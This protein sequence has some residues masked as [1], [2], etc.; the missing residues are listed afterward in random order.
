M[1]FFSVVTYQPLNMH[2]I[3][4]SSLQL[5]TSHCTHLLLYALLLCSYILAIA[6][7]SCYMHFFSVVTYQPLH[8]PLAIYTSSL[9]LH[10][11]HCTHLLYTL[12][13]CSYILA[14]AHTSCYMHFFSVVTYQPLHT[15]LICTSSLQL[16]TSHCTHLL[17]YALL[18]CS[19]I[20]AIAHTSCYMH[21]FS[22]VT[23]QPLHTPLAICT[24]SLQLHTSHCTH[25]LLYTLL[26]CS[27]I[28]AIA[29]TSYIHFFSVVIAH[30]SCYMHFFSVVTYQPLHT[31]LICTSSLQLHTSHCTHL[32]LY[33]LLL[34]S[35]TLAIAHTSC[36]MHF[37][38]VVTYQPLHT[39]LAMYT[40]SLQLHTSHCT[41][42]LLY[43][44]LLCSYILAI[45]HTSCYV[46]FFSVVTYQPLHTPLAICTSSLQLHT[47]HCTHLLLYALLLCSYI[48]ASAHTS[49]YM[50]FFSVVTYQPLHTSLAICTSSPQLR[51]SHCTHLLLYTLLLC[52]YI[53]AIAHTSCYMHFFSVVTYQ[54]LHTPLAICTSSLQ[55]HTSHC[56]HLLLYALLLCSDILA[57]AHTSCYVHFFSVVT[58]QL[59]HTPLAMYTS[60]L[61][62]H[63]SHCTH[64]LLYALLLCSYILAIAHTSCYIHFFSVVTYQPLHTPLAMYTSSLQ[65]HTSH[66]THLLLYALLLCSYIL[67]IAHTSCYVHFFSVVTYQPLH[68]PLAICTASLQLHTSHCT[69]LLLY[70]LLLCSY[71]LASAHTS[72]YMHFF[73][74]VTY[75]PLH[76][77][78]AICTSSL[79]LRTSHCT[80]LLLYT[81]LLCSYILAI[82][83]TSCYV[84]FFSVVTYQ[85][86]H[87]PLA[88]CTSSLQLHTSH[89]THLLLC[90]LLLCSYILAIAHTSCYMHFFSVVTYQPLHTPLAICTSSLQ[91]H[92]SHCTHLL[93]TLLLCSYIL[94]IAHTS[95]YMH[96]FS[97]VTYQPLNMHLICTSSLQLHTSHCTHLLLYALLL[98]SYIL[99]IAH[100]YCYMH[101]FSVVTYQP[102]HTPLAIYTSS[103]QL[104]TSHCTHLLY[105]L[106][107]CS[108]ILAMHFFSLHT[109]AHTSCYM[110][111]FS[112][113][114]YQPLHTHLICTSSLQLHTSHCTH[115]LLYALLLCSYIL[116]IAHTSC[117]MH[118]FSVVTYQPLHTPLAI[119]T[120]SLQLHTS[121]CT[122]LL[123]Y[124]LLLCSYILAIAHTSY[125]HFFSVVI[126]HTSCYMHFFSVVT[127]QPLHTHL[128]CTSSLQL[129][130]SHCTHLLLYA[131]LLCS[132]TLA[133]AHTSC[134]MHFFSVVTY[135]PLHTPLA[136]YTSSLQLHTSHCTHLLL[137]ALL[138]CSYILAIAHT[139]CYVHFFSVVTYQPLHTPLAICTSSLQLHTSH[140]THLLLYALLLCS[141][142]L[143]SAHTS[144]YMHFFS[145]V[146]YQPLHTSLAICTSSPQLRTSHCTHLLLYTL[147][148]C[149]YI[150]AIAHTSC[151]MHFFSVVTYQ[152]LHTPLAICTSSLQ[153]HTSHCT[154]LLLYALLL[155]S[156]ILAIA[157]TSC[158]MHFFSVVTYQPLHTPLAMYTSSLQLHTSHCTHLLLCT[159]LLCSYI[160]AIAHTSCYMHFFSVVTYQPLHTPLAIYTS[161]L[162][163]HT[164]H[165]THLLLCT[166]LLCSYILAIAHT[167]CY[168]H[169]FSVVTYQPLHTP[170]AMYTS[171]L[172]LHTSHCTHVLL[173]ALLLCSYILAIAH[174]SCYMHFFSVVTYQPVHTPLAICT[175]SL[176]LH[177]SHCTHLLL[178]ALL[179]CSYVLAIAHTSCYIH[180]FSVVTYQPL[181][182]PLAICTSSLQLHTSHC[183]HL[184]LYTLLLCS[185]I[186]AIAH[187]SCYVHFFSVVTY[188]PLHTPLAIC[189]S[190]LQLHTSHCTHLLLCTL[191][192]CSYI[193]AIA[194]TSCYMHFFSVVT[195][196]PLH[197]PLAICTSSLQLHTSQCT[198]LLLYALLLCSYVLAIEHTSC[199]IHFFSVVT[200]QPLHTPL[201]ICTSSLQL[202]QLHTS[203]CTHLLLYALLLCSYILTIAHTSCYMHFFS[204]VTYQPLHTPL[205]KCTSSL[206]LH[207]SHCTHLLLCTLLLC[208]YIL[209]IAHTSCY[210]PFF[211]VVTY[212]PLHTPLAIYTSSLQ[213]H[214]SHCTHLLLY[215]LLLCS[216]ILAIAHTSCY[217]H[218]FSVVTYQ[219]LHTPL[220]ICTSSL[221]LHTS[222]CTHLLLYTLLLCSYI[223]AIAHTSYIYFF[224]VVT[225]QPLHTPLAI[226]TSSLQL[227][228]SHC[229]RILYALLLC[230]YILAIAHISCYIHFFSVVTYQ[231]LHTP[232]AICTFFSVVT[233][234]PLHTPLAICTSSLQLHTSH[235]TH[236][237]LCTLLLCSY[238]LAIAHTSCYIH[239]FSVVTYQPLHTPL[240]ICTSSLQLHTSHCTH[241]LLYAL[242]LCSYILAIA[243]TSC[244]MHFFSVV[245]HQPLHTPLAIC[246]SSLQLH[247]SHCTH[248]F[249]YTL[250]LYSYIL[251]ISH[252]S[253]YMHFFSVVTHQPLHTP[254]AI[255]TS[256][257][258]LH[259]SHCT[260]LLLCTLLL[261]SYILAIAHTSCYMHFFS[262]VTY[263]PLHTPL[264]MY[265]S[266]LQLHTSHCTHLLLYALLL[267][268]YI[269]AIAHTSCYM[270]FFSVVTYQP[271]HTPLAMYTSSLQLHTSHC[272]HVLLYALL[273]CSY[274]LA[275]AH[276]SCYM[277]FFSVVTY[278]PVH[279]PLAICTSSLQLHTS[280]CTHLLLYALLLCSYVLAIAHTSCYIHFF[281]VVTY[282]P[283][284]TPLAIC[285]SSLQLHTSH[286]THLLLYALLLCSYILAIAHTSCYIHF[287][288]VVT[289]Q[290]LHTPLAMYTSSLQLHT[291]H[292]TH[293]LLYALLLC[294]YILAIAHTSCY[295]FSVCTLLLCSYIL[296]IAH[297]S[298]YIHFFSVVTYQPL[299]TPL[300]YTSSLQLHTSHCT[301]L[302]LY[303]LLLCSYILAIAHASYM[304]FFSV[305]TYQP[306][307]TSLAIYTSSLQL[308][309]SHCTHLLLYARSSLQLHTSHCTHLLLYALLLCSYILAIAHTSCYVH[310][311]SVVT[312]QPLHTPLAMYTSSLQLHT[313]HCTHV[314]LYALLLCSYILAIAHTSCYMH[315]F[316]VV[317]YQPVHTPLAICTS[318]LQLHTSHCTH[319]LLYALL[320]CSYVLAIA[321]TS[322]YIHFFSVVTYQPLHT[323]LAI[324]TSSLQLHTSHCTHLLLYALL[325]CSYILAIAH[326]SCYIHFFSVVTYQPLHTPLAMYTS[327]LQLHTSFCTHLLLYALLLCSYILAIA[328]TSCYVHFFS[329][330]TYQP[331]HTRLAICTSS[332]Q[333]H[334]SHCTHLLLYALL[335]CSYILASAH[336]SCYMHFFSVV[337][338]QPLNTPLA[339]YTSSLQLHTSH[340]T[341]LLLYALLLC[342][343]CSYILAIAHT[344]CYMHFF[345]VVTYQ[346][347]HTPLAICTS[348][349][350]LH[351]S[352]CTHL[353]LNALL[354]C[355]YILAIAHTSC[356]V[357]FFSVVTYQ[358]LHTPLAIYPSSLQLHTSHCTHL[359]LYTLLLCSYILAIAHTSC[360]MHFFSVV[361]YQ[362]LHTP[363]AI[364]TSSLQ[365]HTSHC[366]HLLLYALLLCSYIL[367]IAHTS[368][369]IHF[370]SS[371]CTH[372]LLYT[373]LLCSYILAIAHTSYIYFFSVVTYQPLHTPLAIYT[374]SLQLH[375]SHCTHLLLYALL[376]CSYILAIA[377][378]SCYVHFFSVVT[379]QPLHTP[380]AIYPSS[381]QLHTSHC[382]HLLLYTLLLCSYILAIAHTSCYMHFFSVV[383]YQ[384]LHTPLAICTSSLQLH[385]SHCTH[386]LLYALLLCSYILA[387]AHTS[388]YIHFFSV[389]TYQPLHTPLIYT[390]SLQLHTSHCTHLLLYTL[391]LCSYILAIA[392]ASCYM[393]FFSVVTYQPLHTSL[394]IYTS[395]LQL[396]TS[397]CTHLL[398]Y[399]RSSL[400]LHTSHC[401]HLLL[402]P[403]LLCSYILAIAHT[404]FYVH[405]FSVVTYQPLHTPLAICTS[406]L[407]L[408]T[409]HCTHLLL[410]ALLLCSYIVAIAHTSCYMHFFS[411]VTYQPLHTSL[412]IYTSSLQLHTSHCTHLLLYALLLCSYIL[413]IA[414]TSS[415]IHFFSIVTYQPLHTPL[416]ICT[417]SLQLHTSH[418]THLLLYALLLC[419]YILA[420]A[421]T[422]CYVHFFS[423]VTYQPLH[424][425]L[426]ICTSSLQLHTS[427]CTHLLLC[428]LL[429]CSQLHTSHCT[430]LLLY[431]LLLCSYILAIAHTSCYV[432]F[433]SVVSYQPLH[434]P[435]AI[436]TSSLQLH[437]SHCTHLLLYALLLCSYVLAIAH[438][439]CYIHFFSVVTYQPL[440]TPLAICTSSLQL[441]TS[442]CTHLLLYALLLCSYILAIAHTSCY[443][444][445]FSVVTYQPLHTPL[446]MYTSSLQLHTIY[447]THLL[448]CTL[449]LCS[450]ILAIGHT[451]CYMHFFS[452]VTYQP[453]H[454]PLAI[455]TSS[456]QLHTSHCTHLLLCTLLL[457][458]YILA[459]AHTSC[460]MHFF[461]VVTYQPLHTPLAICTSS[462][463][464]HTSH[465]THLLLCTLLLCSYI[466]AIAHTSC[467]M[468]FFSVVT[469]QPLHT[470]LAI[471]TSSLQLHTSQ[472]T[473]LLLYALLLCSYILAIA[474]ISCYMHFF[475]VVT[476]QSLPHLLL[477]TLLLCSYILAI[478]HTSCYMHFFSVVTYQPLH[479][480]LAIC[481]SSLQL[482]TSHCTHLLLYALLLCSYILAIAHTSCY[483]HFFS[484]VT[485]Q[486]LHTPLAMYTSSLQLHTSHCT[487]LLLYALLLCSYI[488]AI[489]HT[490]C[491]IHFIRSILFQV[492]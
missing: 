366:T 489:A 438:T 213:L 182:T 261:C 258:Q 146:T 472:C 402:Y 394:A 17:L 461:S 177:T 35:Y 307:H 372:L 335:L 441:H 115:L 23:Y 103:L 142:I 229:T 76:T 121:H 41:H 118:F 358:P 396:H 492:R 68:T 255:C 191:L 10:T 345:S 310:F 407:Q 425:P 355:S 263:Q 13:L 87:T 426:A 470:P 488:L 127:Y 404:S 14:I 2:L 138:L 308:H 436:C 386:L 362:P 343:Y 204:V 326:T 154:H 200:Y 22:V 167:S 437:T 334:T 236:L 150:L 222:H 429:L 333:L 54:P 212:Q 447:C 432:H 266:S 90:T 203:H 66:C 34:C 368:C 20:L 225:Y 327:S 19:Y 460:Y 352:H 479:T 410:Y 476:Y 89:C 371:H 393:H 314:L 257:L 306:L 360:Y 262:V 287:F 53:L 299:H 484:V 139:S 332:L 317:T 99:A 356:Y 42:L 128:I 349:L 405:F 260:H 159:L 43:A 62:L 147:L 439:S 469:Y 318:S 239:F 94:A 3:C 417:S 293:L 278:Q 28:L 264:A 57:I 125:I 313:S 272:T 448:L 361:T 70:A 185:Y 162:Q 467:Y 398:L 122:H 85:P 234:Q 98:C 15:H 259:T 168:M 26:L 101:F 400:Q 130:T 483:V 36:Y 56:T 269:L 95:C 126:A 369:Y 244:Y 63:T 428:T 71:T 183:T 453:L 490:S 193:L 459:I 338:Y 199:Y 29:H 227:H 465:C 385:T 4:T 170:L 148:L 406:S 302:L 206:Q 383:T 330:V 285:T 434:T 86:L 9:Q 411:V 397:H 477:Y 377:H 215:A 319:L 161:S 110:H 176:Q 241:L 186:L 207:T 180:F 104:H 81:L 155:C 289:Y 116:A 105:T 102:L 390:S 217:M 276:T 480:P 201:A 6:H 165:C 108:Y 322:C 50:H 401:T 350:Q 52:S 75:Q 187:T 117:Y 92:T 209:A 364:C 370:F 153:L 347:L 485:Y 49:C 184:L 378:T 173:Y 392:H 403:L 39:P 420:I 178:Y 157:H 418:C 279:T 430:H 292:C 440:H 136:M 114:T 328:H 24:S 487:H 67:A 214:T 329:V 254:L 5:H 181:H 172:Q 237:L 408:Y 340:C 445:F 294:S 391:L 219:P 248:L 421:H 367:A 134:Y 342:S 433:F 357:H 216:Y 47:S 283:L 354:L 7:T 30:T 175:S 388:C 221:Q 151:Y 218:F 58:Y 389:V 202:L 415:Y 32:L 422:S 243:H 137:Y 27:Y 339:I 113:V 91:L 295:F 309:T 454:T 188:Q 431:A 194:H 466:L 323:P 379:Y 208:S 321:H 458:S 44:L 238:I 109:P 111:F 331:L 341:H 301:H 240:A 16:H 198:H 481:T 348:S 409:S 478:A 250:L 471:C 281:S 231:P 140:C 120:S 79:Q 166:L 475:S 195:Y 320:L 300:I 267:C 473:H 336:T 18:L 133:I 457:C 242:L 346:P 235:C 450:Y 45:A 384:P 21:F 37:F 73:S 232:L 25:L 474:H 253:C 435:L 40:S 82:A 190:S 33:A 141:Y 455:Y 77:S 463:Q 48:L 135:Q 8:T 270:H 100:T 156:D 312:Y 131:L 373:L 271:L 284:H 230:S 93:Y 228:T 288:S 446:A 277:H 171:S 412:A 423:V 223:L 145:V 268:S 275:I 298:C 72:C 189:T 413:T 197:T 210:I 158:Y 226:Y 443:M 88:I 296:A 65:L 152:P 163:L 179:L 144:C 316:S 160:L 462:L 192:L 196:Q 107:L 31:H 451:S 119:C 51:T 280:H 395:S 246:T 233:Y 387:I 464:L 84:H 419:S 252:T 132:Y 468:H 273:L 106:L 174:T 303:T 64:L 59:L 83:H 12:L 38:S 61:Q 282:Q 55:L 274:I 251:A 286:C 414:H 46:H 324:C 304:H 382:T 143:A 124:T 291:S 337:T 297:T 482:H 11:S 247:T 69:H 220:A 452:V 123:L 74:V 416:A 381:L 427:H 491:Y 456:L 224:S 344:S 376:L 149:S 442:H 96:F 353:L 205:A 290:P 486:L 265:T 424:T 380:L 305:V 325:L 1:H 249:L 365:L 60:S 311:F 315:F 164:S 359:L 245:T 112:V 399:A 363:L 444:H 449:L 78:L 169:F 351:T 256:S 211:S 374:S 129:H 375:T 97:V 80:H